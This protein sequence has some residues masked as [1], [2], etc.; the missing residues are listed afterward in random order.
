MAP[1]YL[2]TEDNFDDREIDFS[3]EPHNNVDSPA[4]KWG[5]WSERWYWLLSPDL[6]EQYEVRLEEGLDAFVVVDGLP[7]VTEALRPKLVKFLLRKLTEAG[8][9]NADAIFMPLNDNTKMTEGWVATL[10]FHW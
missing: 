1:Q 7:S 4:L 10:I 9:T 3:G 5:E 8:K 2:D 6:K